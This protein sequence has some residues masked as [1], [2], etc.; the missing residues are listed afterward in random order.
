MRYLY[1]TTN[2]INSKKYVG[3]RNCP[4]KTTPQKDLYLG[5]GRLLVSAIKK[6]GK[7]NFDREIIAI[8]DTQKEIDIIEINF[9]KNND[10]LKNKDKWYNIDAGGQYGRGENHQKIKSELMKQYYSEKENRNKVIIG[11]NNKRKKEGVPELPYKNYD[12]QIAYK[13]QAKTLKSIKTHINNKIKSIKSRKRKSLKAVK[14]L[15][16]YKNHIK[17]LMV[18]KNKNRWA[19]DEYRN[20]VSKSHKEIWENRKQLGISWTDDAK[21][22]FVIGKFKLSNNIVALY[23]L[24]KNIN[25]FRTNGLRN[26]ITKLKGKYKDESK[27]LSQIDNVINCIKDNYDIIINRD[28]FIDIVYKWIRCVSA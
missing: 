9:I 21:Q 15:P 14:S 26:K 4:K 28:E 22:S 24:D 27:R 10:V 5:S 7:S 23:L 3:Q 18:I 8:C 17:S 11:I 12:E 20:K 19:S 13:K 2:L 25:D 16:E 1:V 6:Y